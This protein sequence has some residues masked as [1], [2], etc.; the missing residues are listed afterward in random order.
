[1]AL[2][3]YD[4]YSHIFF[5]TYSG[6]PCTL[7]KLGTIFP[8]AFWAFRHQDFS[9]DGFIGRVVLMYSSTMGNI[10]FGSGM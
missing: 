3:E 2:L 8:Y 5:F 7:L 4:C 6:S 9:D 10:L 1:M